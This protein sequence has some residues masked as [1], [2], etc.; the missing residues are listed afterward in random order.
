MLN[1]VMYTKFERLHSSPSIFIFGGQFR[2]KV[3]VYNYAFP[4]NT[5]ICFSSLL[6]RGLLVKLKLKNRKKTFTL[7][8]NFENDL[9]Q[10]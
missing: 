3:N 1:T 5:V 7:N 8:R 9:I 2:K 4:C 6:F 10:E